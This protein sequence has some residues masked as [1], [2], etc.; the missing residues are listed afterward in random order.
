V[1]VTL[2]FVINMI[3][4]LFSNYV[5]WSQKIV[6]GLV[7]F[8]CRFIWLKDEG[9][10]VVLLLTTGPEASEWESVEQGNQC[11]LLESDW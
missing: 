6:P 10:R 5:M 9:S 4:S 3:S 11:W 8:E 7:S 2:N 1:L